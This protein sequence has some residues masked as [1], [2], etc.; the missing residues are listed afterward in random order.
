MRLWE[1]VWEPVWLAQRSAPLSGLALS[2]GFVLALTRVV[3]RWLVNMLVRGLL[4]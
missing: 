3:M 2:A 4:R 1:P